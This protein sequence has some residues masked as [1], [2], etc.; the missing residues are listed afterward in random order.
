MSSVAVR[1]RDS[2]VPAL[3]NGVINA[4]ISYAGFRQSADVPLTVNEIAGGEKSA[5]AEG[6]LIAFTLGLILTFIG[7]ATFRKHAVKHDPSVAPLVNRPFFPFVAG[8]AVRNAV[9]LFGVLAIAALLWQ[10][11]VGTVRVSPGVAAA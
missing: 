1:P 8:V 10:R 3:L 7:A 6:V 4:G 9:F 11:G 5:L 2:L